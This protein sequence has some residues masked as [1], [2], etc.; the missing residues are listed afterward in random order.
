MHAG[1]TELDGQ[2]AVKLDGEDGAAEAPAVVPEASTIAAG[3]ANA[4]AEANWDNENKLNSSITSGPDGWVEVPRDPAETET[5][6]TATPAATGN[7]S[8]A[9]DIPTDPSPATAANNNDGFREVHHNRGRGRGGNYRGEGGR[10]GNRGR[11]GFRGRGR[12]G[13]EGRGGRGRGGPRGGQGGQGGQRE[14]GGG[15]QSSSQQQVGGEGS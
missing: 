11:G 6:L 15:T 2:T 13:G 14:R 12:G 1:L 5:G 7:Q 10:G 4:A 8:W 9:E 3:A